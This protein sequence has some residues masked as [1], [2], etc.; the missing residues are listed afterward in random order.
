MR[1]LVWLVAAAAS[2]L[3]AGAADAGVEVTM[4]MD[5]DAGG[6]R[7]GGMTLLLDADRLRQTMGPVDMIYRA[8]LAKAWMLN[9]TSHSYREM[10]QQSMQQQRARMDE[11]MQRMQQQMQSMP[12]EQRKRIEA[13]M[14]KSGMAPNAPPPAPPTYTKA[15]PDKTVGKWS[16]TPF[17]VSAN[18]NDRQ[19]MCLAKL[20]DLGL[21]RDDFKA[22]A[23]FTT[24]MRQMMPNGAATQVGFDFDGMTK[25]VGFDG[26]PVQWAMYGDDG[27]VEMQAT[28]TSIE[29]KT[30]PADIFELP[31]GYTKQ[32]MPGP[33]GRP[34]P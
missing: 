1:R 9:T 14:G 33:P 16:C 2:C 34:Q 20:S 8:D 5:P 27:K 13:M 15:G 23:S 6:A 11:A 10:N 24:F 25:A 22:Y 18:G 31:A 21:K 26:F 28:T 7:G 4:T 32:E 3:V 30:I 19:E 29:R 17:R 12:E